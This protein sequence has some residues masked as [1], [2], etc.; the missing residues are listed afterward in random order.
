ME[1]SDILFLSPIICF[2][3]KKQFLTPGVVQQ[4]TNVGVLARHIVTV[5]IFVG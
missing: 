3:Q 5:D 4:N 1:H 2:L